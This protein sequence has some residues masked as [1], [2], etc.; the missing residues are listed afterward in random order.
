MPMRAG[1]PCLSA[2][3]GARLTRERQQAP[4]FCAQK[5]SNFCASD[6]A[7][8][9]VSLPWLSPPDGAAAPPPLEALFVP[10]SAPVPPVPEVPVVPVVPVVVGVVPDEAFVPADGVVPVDPVA[11]DVPVVAVG[12]GVGVAVLLELELSGE[13]A[14]GASAE[15]GIG[16]AE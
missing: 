15:V 11:P 2:G 16:A 13:G 1:S 9:G 7:G 6:P 10:V 5:S 3:R 8:G 4:G 12:V 14:A